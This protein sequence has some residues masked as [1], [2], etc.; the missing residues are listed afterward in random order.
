MCE[1]F[2]T[3]MEWR[4]RPWMVREPRRDRFNDSLER[5]TYSTYKERPTRRIPGGPQTSHSGQSGLRH[6]HTS[7]FSLD[8]SV[9]CMLISSSLPFLSTIKRL[10]LFEDVLLFNVF[11]PVQLLRRQG[12]CQ[13]NTRWLICGEPVCGSCHTSNSENK[14]EKICW[15]VQTCAGRGAQMGFHFAGP[16]TERSPVKWWS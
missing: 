4:K 5:Q 16:S 3:G 11:E 13:D 9:S 2:W 8:R 14:S 7:T 6:Y 12:S 1:G 10:G 15:Q